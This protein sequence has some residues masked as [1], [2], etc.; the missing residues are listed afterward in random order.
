[1]DV[2]FERADGIDGWDGGEYGLYDIGK[3][4]EVEHN[5]LLKT[6]VFARADASIVLT[7]GT[8]VGTM[9]E[10]GR[11]PASAMR[12]VAKAAADG[13]HL[14]V[15]I[16]WKTATMRA[17]ASQAELKIDPNGRVVLVGEDA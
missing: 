16:I 9:V 11:M 3:I 4:N 2:L 12:S 17:L 5:W 1:M 6:S 15:G 8:V 10:F 14:T 13:D 7:N